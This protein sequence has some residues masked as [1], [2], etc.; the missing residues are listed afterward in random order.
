METR[1][2]TERAAQ[3]GETA[4]E[5]R[6]E[7]NA[8]REGLEDIRVKMRAEGIDG[9]LEKRIASA[10][11]AVR[12]REAEADEANRKIGVARERLESL[13]HARAARE[14]EAEAAAA[15]AEAALARFA[16][17]IPE[18][19]A[20]AEF[21]AANGVAKARA[22]D[23]ELRAVPTDGSPPMVKRFLSPAFHKLKEDEPDR[24]TFWM[25]VLELPQDADYHIEIY[26]RNCF[27]ACGK[28]LI[29]AMRRGKPGGAHARGYPKKG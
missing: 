9:S 25:N 18:G 13:A 7:A 14:H 26:P 20:V 21:A 3:A 23:Y 8:E 22:F 17:A 1:H 16:S 2:A 15:Q 4:K 19:T 28:P 29:S 27:G 12:T 10:E 6:R 5:R 24:L 11:K